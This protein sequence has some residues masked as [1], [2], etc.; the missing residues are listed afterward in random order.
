MNIATR[1]IVTMFK[2]DIDDKASHFVT[3]KLRF[4]C[5]K[6]DKFIWI[7][8][9]G[10]YVMANHSALFGVA[11]LWPFATHWKQVAHWVQ[12]VANLC[13]REFWFWPSAV[14]GVKCARCPENGGY[15]EHFHRKSARGPLGYEKRHPRKDVSVKSDN[16]SKNYSKA[17]QRRVIRVSETFIESRSS[18]DARPEQSE[19]SVCP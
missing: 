13:V 1:F 11:F 5:V 18:G 19:W 12:G 10:L 17:H 6:V 7:T 16:R 8:M 15:R 3:H 14:L 2:F 4:V 9:A